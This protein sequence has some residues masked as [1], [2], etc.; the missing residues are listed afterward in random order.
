MMMIAQGPS[1]SLD[2]QA[3]TNNSLFPPV[4]QTAFVNCQPLSPVFP[5]YTRHQC[6]FSNP[7]TSRRLRLIQSQAQGRQARTLPTHGL[8]TLVELTST[9][10]AQVSHN[11]PYSPPTTTTTLTILK[12]RRANLIPPTYSVE[13]LLNYQAMLKGG[14]D[15]RVCQ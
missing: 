15:V 3:L 6:G 10:T 11:R 8:P 12:T 7:A 1:R 14:A 4:A 2:E 9:L 13:V 5:S